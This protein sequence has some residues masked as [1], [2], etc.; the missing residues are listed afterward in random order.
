MRAGSL[1]LEELFQRYYPYVAAVALRVTG[2]VDLA[3]DIAQDV[4]VQA[5]RKLHT[6]R[7]P[8]AVR[9][10]L[11]SIA[12]R[13]AQQLLR[14]RSLL[15]WV[16]L[17]DAPDRDAVAPDASPEQRAQLA[18]VFETLERV[19]VRERIAWSLRHLQGETL[20]EVARLAGCSLATAKRRI[21]AADKKLKEWMADA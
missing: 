2:D 10:W 17:E 6:L 19:P 8:E 4:F 3:D 15:R 1:E 13:R 21:A 5:C 14:R 7:E 16:G 20:T 9:G 12:V 18:Q 11:A